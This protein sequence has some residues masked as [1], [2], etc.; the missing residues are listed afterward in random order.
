MSQ[1]LRKKRR[2]LESP[3]DLNLIPIMNLF[4]CLLPFLLLTAAFTQLGAVDS[5]LPTTQNAKT[6]IENTKDQNQ[7]V[8]LVFELTDKQIM[9]TGFQNGFRQAI[10]GLQAALKWNDYEA[11]NQFLDEVSEKYI[12]ISA[13]LYKVSP[14]VSYSDAVVVLSTLRQHPK[15]PSITL[16]AEAI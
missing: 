11:L 7:R 13:G 8:E 3:D 4:V 2:V 10:P 6:E 9:I 16:A 5:E 12:E 1:R 14:G 15:L